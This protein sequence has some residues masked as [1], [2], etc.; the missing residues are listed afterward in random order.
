MDR[1]EDVQ[2]IFNLQNGATKRI[3]ANKTAL[4]SRSP[5]FQAMFFGQLKEKGDVEIVDTSPEA[6]QEFMGLFQ[7]THEIF[8]MNNFTE[9]IKMVDKYDVGDFWPVCTNF[10]KKNADINDIVGMF[11]LSVARDLDELKEFCVFEIENTENIFEK[12]SISSLS[13]ERLSALLD[14]EL[15][16][17]E[18]EVFEACVSWAQT[19]CESEKIEKTSSNLR[20]VLGEVVTKIRFNAMTPNEFSKILSSYPDFFKIDEVVPILAKITEE[21]QEPEHYYL[22]KGFHPIEKIL[23]KR[24]MN[25]KVNV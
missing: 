8:S 1:G 7:G 18:F 10:L 4:A 12:V 23:E 15:Q 6:F 16:C 21:H 9:V 20:V 5:V 25:G 19:K 13:R 17:K 3:R 24:E 22:K 2:F 11:Q 14:F